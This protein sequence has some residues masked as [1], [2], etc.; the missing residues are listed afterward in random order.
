MTT[1]PSPPHRILVLLLMQALTRE[2]N[3]AI[4]GIRQATMSTTDLHSD[5]D[6]FGEGGELSRETGVGLRVAERETDGA[7]GGHDFEKDGEEGEGRLTEVFEPRALDNGDEEEAEEDVPQI[8]G[9]LATEMGAEI[10][11]ARRVFFDAVVYTEGSLLVHICLTQTDGD[12]EDGNVHHDEIGDLD[13][14]MQFGYVNNGETG[15][16][17]RKRKPGGSEVTVG[18]LSYNIFIRLRPRSDIQQNLHRV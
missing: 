18:S 1:S 6:E 11:A 13:G 12:G 14:W 4:K 10:A 17:S 3:S 15:R 2:Q 5:D 16:P 7:V 8:E 9:E